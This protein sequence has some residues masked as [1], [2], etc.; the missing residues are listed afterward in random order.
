M[1][2]VLLIAKKNCPL[3]KKIFYFEKR[4]KKIYFIQSDLNN[5]KILKKLMGIKKNQYDYL[6]CF[7]S[8]LILKKNILSK[9][10]FASINFHP[11]PPSYRGI[12]CANFA[13]IN[14]EKKIR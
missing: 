11:G 6:I 12:G 7:R 13:L 9:I 4:I 2:N 1:F 8:Y 5:G 3:S 10:K 14:N